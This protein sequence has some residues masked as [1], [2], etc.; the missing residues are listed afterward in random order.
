MYVVC[1]RSHYVWNAH[2]NFSEYTW[3]AVALA[4]ILATLH[5][6]AGAIVI[7]EPVV[8][9]LASVWVILGT[10]MS[11]AFFGAF[12]HRLILRAMASAIERALYK[13]RAWSI[14]VEVKSI[15]KVFISFCV[16]KRALA[17]F[18][19]EASEPVDVDAHGA[20]GDSS[21]QNFGEHFWMCLSDFLF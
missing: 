17:I 18:D 7:H 12:F 20:G 19:L 9:Q 4:G 14:S 3:G 2:N 6:R 5:V 1:E 13:L 11:S 16:V 8:V 15:G 21:D 10:A